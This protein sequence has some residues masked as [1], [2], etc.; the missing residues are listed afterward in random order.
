MKPTQL[1]AFC[2]LS[3]AFL[4]PLAGAGES[5]SVI[6]EEKKPKEGNNGNWC[7]WLSDSPGLIYTSRRRDNPYVQTLRIS[8]RFHYQA[9]YVS[10]TDVRGNDFN[11]THDEFRRARIEGRFDFL[12]Y[13]RSEVNVNLVSDSRFRG[14][15]LDWGYDTFD[16]ATLR[17]DIGR[18]FDS[19]PL[20]SLRLTYGRMKLKM[21]EED[22][23]SSRRILTIER[24]AIADKIGGDLS[25]PTGAMLELSK[26]DWDAML[27]LFSG[28]I[29]R[30]TLAGWG[31]G[32]A[33][34]ASIAW[35]TTKELRLLLDY[36][37]NDAKG[38]EDFLGYSWGVSLGATYQ[39][40]RWGVMA[41]LL[42]GDNGGEANGWSDPRRQGDF[43]GLVVL[44]WYWLVE[45]KL[46]LVFRYQYQ[47]SDESE[48]VRIESRYAR[49][50]HNTPAVDLDSG[51]GDSHHAFYLGLNYYLCDHNAKIMAGISY[52]EM[53]ARTASFDATSYLIGFRT[54]F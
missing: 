38:G 25:R 53:R 41:N 37:E 20:D 5:K 7:D 28:E 22:H 3:A 18:L 35:Q 49:A 16:E 13:F 48:G 43:H 17:F 19:I 51:Y 54:S 14:Q 50:S 31:A 4:P 47:G 32:K 29:D 1:L 46:Q 33:Y 12:K 2:I 39:Q 10:G 23:E 9:A 52:D 30:S 6:E 40:D 45:K 42:Y 11:E 21:G 26:G 44:P 36:I 24:S 15:D 34:Y 27:G 8:G